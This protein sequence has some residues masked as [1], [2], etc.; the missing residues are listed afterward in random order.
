MSEVATEAAK[1]DVKSMSKT[2]RTEL[3]RIVRRRFKMLREQLS[4]RERELFHALKTQAE[5]ERKDAVKEIEK[6]MKPLIKRQNDL[7]EAIEKVMEEAYNSDVSLD[8]KLAQRIIPGSKYDDIEI[9]ARSDIASSEAAK[10]LKEI[11]EEAGW[12][13]LNLEEL[14]WKLDEQLAVG[15]L[16]SGSSKG[17]LEALPTVESLLPLP[18]GITL[19]EIVA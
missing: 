9:R 18:K 3:R 12:Q 13:R 4:R 16:E 19:P 11:K 2:E 10:Q 8:G 1:I 5:Q 14:E 15:E 7:A 17:F 6:K